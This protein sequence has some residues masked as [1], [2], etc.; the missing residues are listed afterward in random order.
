MAMSVVSESG[1]RMAPWSVQNDRTKAEGLYYVGPADAWGFTTEQDL[2][3]KHDDA[4]RWFNIAVGLSS[5]PILNMVA[6]YIFASMA[7][8]LSNCESE[9]P[10]AYRRHLIG[11]A[12][13]TAVVGFVPFVMPIVF[14][15]GTAVQYFV[16][17]R[18]R[19][20]VLV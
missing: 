12:I 11:M 7:S 13:T 6:V 14:G 20:P 3:N 8:E 10:V 1:C 2:I 9:E 4:C 15:I 16:I 5:V 17:C 18:P 19:D